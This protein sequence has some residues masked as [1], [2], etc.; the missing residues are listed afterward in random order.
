MPVDAILER[1]EHLPIL[2]L[3]VTEDTAVQV[4]RARA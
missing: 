1:V 3:Q 2:V 4:E